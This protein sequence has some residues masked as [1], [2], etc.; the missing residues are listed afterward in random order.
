MMTSPPSS[1]FRGPPLH[2]LVFAYKKRLNGSVI[3]DDGR[4]EHV[5]HFVDGAPD[6]VATDDHIAP[7]LDVLERL[8]LVDADALDLERGTSVSPEEGWPLVQRGLLAEEGLMAARRWQVMRKLEHVLNRPAS[9]RYVVYEGEDLAEPEGETDSAPVDPLA[10]IMQGSRLMSSREVIDANVARYVGLRLCLRRK[11]KQA[12][13]RLT[14]H[15]EAVVDALADSPRRLDELVD[16][17]H[18]EETAR[19]V[20]FGLIVAQSLA[21]APHSDGRAD[22]LSSVP[23]GDGRAG[24][25]AAPPPAAFS[26]P[27][28]SIVPAAPSRPPMVA[29]QP[30]AHPWPMDEAPEPTVPE[31]APSDDGAARDGEA[32]YGRPTPKRPPPAPSAQR[33]AAASRALR[34]GSPPVI[35]SGSLEVELGPTG[36]EP[37]AASEPPAPSAGRGRFGTDPAPP[38]DSL[39]PDPDPPATHRMS[40]ASGESGSHEG[41]SI[42]T[43]PVRLAD[44]AST[45]VRPPA[46]PPTPPPDLPGPPPIPQEAARPSRP[47]QTAWRSQRSADSPL[48]PAGSARPSD[49]MHTGAPVS[50]PSSPGA[51]SRPSSPGAETRSSSPSFPSGP[52]LAPGMGSVEAEPRTREMAMRHFREAESALKVLDRDRAA[53]EIDKALELLPGEARFEA[54]ALWIDAERL[55]L[56]ASDL[57]AKGRHYAKQL[58]A[59]DAIV[60]RAPRLEEAFYYRGRMLKRSGRIKEAI[61]DFRRAGE[62][63]PSNLDAAREVAAYDT[64]RGRR[65]RR[66]PSGASHEPPKAR[67]SLKSEA[68][69]KVSEVADFFKGVL[70]RGRD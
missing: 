4:R 65:G 12:R 10:V 44:A 6:K 53:K 24:P 46:P 35:A 59:L 38:P 47:R 15:E 45:L 42:A 29:G 28:V 50:R 40:Q 8:G 37:P 70:R 60:E 33:F 63:N 3:A 67:P 18:D 20:I 43:E 36:T 55:G 49:P 48:P 30:S 5:L 21:R 23:R 56:P 64:R 17:G 66:K 62:L 54:L 32:L 19:R 57:N 14:T 58:A 11:S 69:N 13:L 2:L 51:A 26:V 25:V 31:E 27:P 68:E 7:L 9:T 52:L 16:M 61:A 22:S 34:H 39:P 41:A 1:S